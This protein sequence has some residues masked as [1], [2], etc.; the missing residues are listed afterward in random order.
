MNTLWRISL[1]AGSLLACL[2][3]WK[4]TQW[5]F[6]ALGCAGDIKHLQPC[7]WAGVD[8]RP[9]IGIGLFWLPILALPLLVITVWE[10]G[11]A[12]EAKLRNEHAS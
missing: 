10:I 8:L 6:A 3:G 9:V 5:A 11:K 12:I 4:L 2:A 7:F 1:A